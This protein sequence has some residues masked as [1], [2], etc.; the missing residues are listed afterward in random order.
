MQELLFVEQFNDAD[1]DVREVSLSDNPCIVAH[2][3]KFP[4]VAKN[5]AILKVFYV[6]KQGKSH[7]YALSFKPPFYYDGAT[8]PFGIGKGDTRLLIPALWHDLMC[9]N[10]EKIGY[11]RHL[12]TLVFKELLIKN[13]IPKAQAEIMACCVDTWQSLQ[14]G[15]NNEHI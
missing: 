10:K 4:F 1:I 3:R 13:K 5:R 11:N 7:E 14:R 9:R 15:W 8:I 2:K 12:S 6:D